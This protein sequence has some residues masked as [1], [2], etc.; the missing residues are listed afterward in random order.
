MGKRVLDKSGYSFLPEGLWE[1]EGFS[2]RLF[3]LFSVG[4]FILVKMAEAT[5]KMIKKEV[6][7]KT[8]WLRRN[9]EGTPERNVH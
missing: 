3:L 8:N 9:K 4:Q 7:L 1:E 5:T 2:L 6:C